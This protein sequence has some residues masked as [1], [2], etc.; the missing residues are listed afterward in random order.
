MLAGGKR[1][2]RRASILVRYRRTCQ[3]RS[4][5]FHSINIDA[6]SQ[7]LR[8]VFSLP[9]PDRDRSSTRS[10]TTAS[11][12]CRHR[13]QAH[14]SRIFALTSQRARY[15][16]DASPERQGIWRRGDDRSN[17]SSIANWEGTHMTRIR[18]RA[19]GRTSCD[20]QEKLEM[21]TAENRP[22]R[23]HDQ[24]LRR[25]R[26]L[27]RPRSAELHRDD[28]RA[29]RTSARRRWKKCTRRSKGSVSIARTA[30]VAAST[31]RPR[32]SDCRK[33]HKSPQDGSPW[34]FL[35]ARRLSERDYDPARGELAILGAASKRASSSRMTG[36]RLRRAGN[37]PTTFDA[38]DE[39]LTRLGEPRRHRSQ[40]LA[41]SAGK[42]VSHELHFRGGAHSRQLRKRS[43]IGF[44]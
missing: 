22:D 21:S 39:R 13:R 33:K 9:E 35:L 3:R 34:A 10:Q 25:T 26:H 42:I 16:S 23:S 32:N 14:F 19:C 31:A 38:T 8:W 44:Q 18:L 4:I 41:V 7:L 11:C 17:H 28:L 29:S 43:A 24:L 36:S 1:G 12:N 37:W 6:K 40:K 2:G 5:A 15:N 30:A 27:H 20:M